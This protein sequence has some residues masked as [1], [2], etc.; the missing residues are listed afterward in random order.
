MIPRPSKIFMKLFCDHELRYIRCRTSS[1]TDTY[2]VWQSSD[3]FVRVAR[4]F[5]SVDQ[6]FLVPPSVVNSQSSGSN[7]KFEWIV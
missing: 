5:L 1:L 3:G 2:T 4:T 7:T 6:D